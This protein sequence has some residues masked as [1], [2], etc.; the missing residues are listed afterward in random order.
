MEL[1][2]QFCIPTLTREA[3]G[4]AARGKVGEGREQGEEPAL[5][6]VA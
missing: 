5:H 1:G 3:Q 2:K 6:R 4:A